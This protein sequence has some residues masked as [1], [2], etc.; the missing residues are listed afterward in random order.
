M[1]SPEA[2]ADLS[3]ALARAATGNQD[4]LNR[5]P[6]CA[7]GAVIGITC[8]AHAGGLPIPGEIAQDVLE[9]AHKWLE[10]RDRTTAL[11]ALALASDGLAV[12]ALIP[13]IKGATYS[14]PDCADLWVDGQRVKGTAKCNGWQV[15][16]NPKTREP[17][18]RCG[19]AGCHGY[20]G[21]TTHGPDVF[22]MFDEHPLAHIGHQPPA[23]VIVLDP[24]QH[25]D[26]DGVID[27]DGPAWLEMMTGL[28][29]ALPETQTA[30]TR[31][32]EG[33]HYFLTVPAGFK[34]TGKRLDTKGVNVKSGSNGLIVVPPEPGS[35]RAWLSY[36]HIAPA[37]AWVLALIEEIRTSTPGNDAVRAAADRNPFD[38][39]VGN[40]QRDTDY[41]LKTPLGFWL[42]PRG[43][44]VVGTGTGDGNGDQWLRPDP[45]KDSKHSAN[46]LVGTDGVARLKIHSD[47]S[48]IPKVWTDDNGKEHTA[49]SAT[50]LKDHFERTTP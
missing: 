50:D 16:P 27:K 5:F 17:G 36:G 1:R 39:K 32:G 31:S 30:A 9:G 3:L 7:V 12:V 22:R 6:C 41:N 40:G 8:R 23:D 37:P 47:N 38:R 46:V 19:R 33:R 20:L 25:A 45:G 29:Y 28:G 26:A 49:Y 4:G 34:F 43:W 14:C 10:E 18:T 2:E 11:G 44:T 35:R 13:G 42:T 21:A 24:D 15:Q 48:P